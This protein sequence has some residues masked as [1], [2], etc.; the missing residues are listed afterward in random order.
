MSLKEKILGKSYDIKVERLN[1]RGPDKWDKAAEIENDKTG[2]K[3]LKLKSD[4]AKLPK[5]GSDKIGKMRYDKLIHKIFGGQNYVDKVTLIDYG[6]GRADFV[7]VDHEQGRVEASGNDRMFET[8][9]NLMSQLYSNLFTE[10]DNTQVWLAAYLTGLAFITIG[11][12]YFVTTGIE[13][14]VADAVQKGIEAGISAGGEAQGA[15]GA[16]TGGG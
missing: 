2:E 15:A 14:T 7:D 5:P 10:E 4:G 8:H 9:R 11:A 16:T 12:M 6:D 1:S 3:M 13:S